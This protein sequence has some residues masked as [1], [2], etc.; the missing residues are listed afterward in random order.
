MSWKLKTKALL[1]NLENEKLLVD[2]L[3]FEEGSR[4]MAIENILVKIDRFT[5]PMD[6]VTWGI[7]GNLQNS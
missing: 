7:E 4:V 2:K 6:F 1:N 5:F 3:E